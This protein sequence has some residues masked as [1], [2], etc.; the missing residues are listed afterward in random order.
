MGPQ[1]DT[2]HVYVTPGTVDAF[3][4]SWTATFGG[5]HMDKVLTT[6]TPTPGKTE[7]E[8]V[9]SYQ[10]LKS[11]PDNRVY[12]T[13]DSVNQFLGSYLRFTGGRVVSDHRAANGGDIGLPE[14]TY[15][16]IAIRSPLATR[17]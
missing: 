5:T 11:V 9:P 15:R 6:V 4:A 7:S 13:A 8:L 17:S 12:L 3:A 1:Y 16:R 14:E 2:T 10:P